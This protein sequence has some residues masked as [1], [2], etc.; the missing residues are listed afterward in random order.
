MSGAA[1]DINRLPEDG[2][3][4]L[5]LSMSR[6]SAGQSP[7]DCYSVFEHFEPKISVMGLDVV[8]L[9]TNG[10]YFN[11][12]EAAL[13]LRTRSIELMTSHKNALLNLIHKNKRY[14]PG[15]F[16]FLP[17]DYVL[18]A[19]DNFS[20]QLNKLKAFYQRSEAMQRAVLADLGP[21]EP[22]TANINFVLEEVCATH[23]IRNHFVELPK[24]LVKADLWRLVIY[25]GAPIAADACQLQNS[26]L[27]AGTKASPYA[28]HHYDFAK[29]QLIDL[30]QVACT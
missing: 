16:H 9:Y 12:D 21:R 30:R 5:P 3:L 7:A 6:L 17:W 11:T 27:P 19:G 20:A 10:L 18:L 14:I 25:P 1:H 15:A 29:R 2:Y 8:L 22:S 23:L 24:T 13:P 26:I 28:D 4:V